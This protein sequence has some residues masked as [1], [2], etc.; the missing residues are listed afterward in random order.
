MSDDHMRVVVAAFAGRK[1]ARSDIYQWLLAHYTELS[2][3]RQSGRRVD[4]VGVA[5]EL[6][7]LGLRSDEGKKTLNPESI[8]RAWHRVDADVKAG[9][10]TPGSPV[11]V[12]APAPSR[13]TTPAIPARAAP[14]RVTTPT[15]DEDDDDKPLDI[16]PV[17]R[18]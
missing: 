8:R 16:R 7:A 18:N 17:T 10:M 2:A 3:A 6:K 11:P 5:G 14:A 13:P 12:A 15:P 4:W 9:I 1:R